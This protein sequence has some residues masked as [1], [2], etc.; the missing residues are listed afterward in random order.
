LIE[1]TVIGVTVTNDAIGGFH[2]VG[3]FQEQR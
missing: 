1:E 3:L 2:L